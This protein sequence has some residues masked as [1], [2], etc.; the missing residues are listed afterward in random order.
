MTFRVL[1]MWT[2]LGRANLSSWLFGFLTKENRYIPWNFEEQLCHSHALSSV[3]LSSHF[4]QKSILASG[5]LSLCRFFH[6][7]SEPRH[8]GECATYLFVIC[9]IRARDCTY[10]NRWIV[11]HEVV[12]CF[13]LRSRL[14]RDKSSGR[15][16]TIVK[17]NE[18]RKFS[19]VR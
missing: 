16:T 18:S 6:S 3:L 5:D 19:F 14:W 7:P 2:M 13:A 1:I 8:I 4:Y 17:R 15:E 12:L 11:N 10:R 9:F